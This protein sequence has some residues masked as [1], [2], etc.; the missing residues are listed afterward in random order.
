MC[1]A[2]LLWMSLTWRQGFSIYPCRV[3]SE[4]LENLEL[5]CHLYLEWKAQGCTSLNSLEFRNWTRMTRGQL[6]HIKKPFSPSLNWI[7]LF[8]L[9]SSKA[10][11]KTKMSK[12]RA[13]GARRRGKRAEGGS[14]RGTQA[15]VW[16]AVRTARRAIMQMVCW[17]IIL[18]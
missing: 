11:M 2:L 16:P 13:L 14:G 17:V 15:A 4:N 18:S 3:A 6:S 9:V 10:Q 12:R 5:D 7:F 1:F 8:R